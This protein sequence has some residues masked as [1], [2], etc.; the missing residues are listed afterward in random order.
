MIP[1]VSIYSSFYQRAYDQV[2]HDVCMQNLPVIMCVDRAGI[3][4][5]DGETHQGL[6]DLSFFKLIPNIVIMSPK[7]FREL[8]AMMEFAITLNKPVVI[9]YPRGGE[10]S[11]LLDSVKE[12]NL[13]KCEKITIGRDVTIVAIGNM[14]SKALEIAE[15][16]KEYKISVEVINSRFLKPFDNFGILKSINKT[17]FVI[18]IEDG[19]CIGGLSSSIKELLIDNKI[20]GVKIKSYC[21]PKC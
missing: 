8:E 14:V 6:Y 5:N 10:S 7:N 12:L 17:K 13:G 15:K 3:V 18:T 11:N 19:T 16:L 1:F 2:I 21:Y 20:N 4:G 9:R